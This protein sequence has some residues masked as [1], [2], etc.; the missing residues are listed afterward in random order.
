MSRFD[1]PPGVP[2]A[3]GIHFFVYHGDDARDDRIGLYPVSDIWV[4][5][6]YCTSA[7][8][9]KARVVMLSLQ[10]IALAVLFIF[11]SQFSH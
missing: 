10:F 2:H 4:A 9:K 1:V 5:G 11:P 3:G 6:W 7:R 8:E